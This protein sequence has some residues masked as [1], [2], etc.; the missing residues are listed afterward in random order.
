MVGLVDLSQQKRR[1]LGRL[2]NGKSR[3][4]EGL[5]LVEGVRA[6]KE[7]IDAGAE[8]R[9]VVASERI[10]STTAGLELA[11]H[12]RKENLDITSVSEKEL[13]ALADTKHPQGI[14]MVCKEQQMELQDILRVGGCY[15]VL[16]GVQDP[17]NVGTLI[18]AAAAFPVDAV[19]TL[20]GTADTW[21]PKTV[22]ASAGVVFRL[23]VAH[24]A[25]EEAIR[26][27]TKAGVPIWVA[28]PGA[29]SLKAKPDDRGFALVLANEGAGPRQAVLDA[30]E[31]MVRVPISGQVDSLNVAVAG[32]ILLYELT[33]T[34]D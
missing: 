5:V 7:A 12:I 20:D 24:A 16:D 29:P 9:F 23:S 15:L 26:E 27:I 14:L 11:E 1:L 2:R 6:V 32:A 19:I 21:A 28:D 18:R 3:K 30:A 33:K 22:R 17:G 8:V 4:R 13:A 25:A 34:E 31:H 10:E